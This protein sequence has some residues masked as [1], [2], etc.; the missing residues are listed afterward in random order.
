MIG[1]I[2]MAAC[3]AGLEWGMCASSAA[4]L[5]H[6]LGHGGGKDRQAGLHCVGEEEWPH[7]YLSLA[8]AGVLLSN[9]L[10]Q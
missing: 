10:L 4:P 3:M 9:H 8:Q 1:A 2:L 6:P 7:G 5:Y